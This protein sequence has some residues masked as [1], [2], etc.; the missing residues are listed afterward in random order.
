[1]SSHLILQNPFCQID[2]RH[3]EHV[4]WFS[5]MWALL[6]FSRTPF[7]R[8]DFRHTE[9]VEWFSP[10]WALLWFF[11]TPFVKLILGIPNMWNDSHQ[12]E[13]SYDFPEPLFCQT[14]FRHT[15]HVEWFSPIWAL[16]WFFRIP[17]LSKWLRH[18]EH[19]ESFSSIWTS[20]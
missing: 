1:M 10:I 7:C 15:E 3:T 5:P 18:T 4:E 9:H 16:L 13:L 8:N 19:V 2:F 6:R 20:I 12:Y 17:F 14:D 11:R